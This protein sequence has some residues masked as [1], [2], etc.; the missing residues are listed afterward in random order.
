MWDKS[1]KHLAL[2]LLFANLAAQTESLAS[3]VFAVCTLSHL[4][5][6][7]YYSFKE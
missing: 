6:S 5:L 7:L 1:E 4:G 3:I 2:G